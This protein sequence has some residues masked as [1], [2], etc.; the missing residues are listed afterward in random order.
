MESASAPG[1]GG[2]AAIDSVRDSGAARKRARE[3]ALPRPTDAYNP[4]GYDPALPSLRGD[5]RLNPG[6]GL[7]VNWHPPQPVTNEWAD[8]TAMPNRPMFNFQARRVLPL[9][10]SLPPAAPAAAATAPPDPR[11]YA[12]AGSTPRPAVPQAVFRPLVPRPSAEVRFAALPTAAPGWVGVARRAAQPPG[13]SPQ[14]VCA[15]QHPPP[16]TCA[17]LTRRR[18]RAVLA[19]GHIGEHAPA[20]AGGGSQAP[21]APAP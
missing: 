5:P 14:F 20:A 12:S 8:W 10:A 18:R 6:T 21:A 9:P 17:G 16:A 19:G 4:Y 15:S 11:M 13:G 3:V 2:G 1:D 7:G